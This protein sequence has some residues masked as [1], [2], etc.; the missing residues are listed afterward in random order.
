MEIDFL[1][2]CIL[3]FLAS[4]LLAFVERAIKS[5]PISQADYEKTYGIPPGLDDLDYQDGGWRYKS[6]GRLATKS[7][8]E[9]AGLVWPKT[10][11]GRKGN[12]SGS[13]TNG[14][15][16]KQTNGADPSTNDKKIA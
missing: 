1:T 2:F 6:S 9:R 7:E 12:S 3:F 14:A 15:P 13:R 4:F 8:I 11:P 5:T 16:E 10:P